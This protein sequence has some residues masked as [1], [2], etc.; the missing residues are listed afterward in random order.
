MTHP[1]QTRHSTRRMQ[2]RA[3][4][5][6]VLRLIET[7]G[8]A[9]YQKGGAEILEIPD[10]ELKQL[11]DAIERVGKVCVVKGQHDRVITVMHRNQRIPATQHIA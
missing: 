4:N 8:E 1:E 7:F 5:Q 6:T 9:R 2:Q 11:R 3:I 10:A